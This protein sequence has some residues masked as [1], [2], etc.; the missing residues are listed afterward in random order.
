LL[1][2]EFIGIRPQTLGKSKKGLHICIIK[3]PNEYLSTIYFI[4]LILKTIKMKTNTFIIGGLLAFSLNLSAQNY[5]SKFAKSFDPQDQSSKLITHQKISKPVF[6]DQFKLAAEL[7][8]DL[9][10][11][12]ELNDLG[13][14]FFVAFQPKKAMGRCQTTS[15]QPIR[16]VNKFHDDF[17]SE[18]RVELRILTL[19][20]PSKS[21]AQIK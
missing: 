15:T 8:E 4:S 19:Q 2:T 18:L 11:F 17:F 16:K 3:R 7:G 21:V 5:D 1:R 13:E 20:A 14:D 6:P 9:D 12:N 10:V